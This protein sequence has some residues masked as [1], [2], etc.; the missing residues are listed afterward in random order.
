VTKTC[1][2]KTDKPRKTHCVEEHENGRRKFK[3]LLMSEHLI[4]NKKSK[5]ASDFM[6]TMAEK[7]P[8][9][10]QKLKILTAMQSLS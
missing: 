4:S 2:S 1:N 9:I 7:D 5:E 6:M 10:L 8:E 3:T